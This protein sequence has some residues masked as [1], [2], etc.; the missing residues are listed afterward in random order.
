MN[1]AMVL[2][3]ITNEIQF[4]ISDK[5]NPVAFFAVAVDRN[6][7]EVDYFNVVCFGK[8][9]ENVSK[10]CVRGQE[11]LVSGSFQLT[12]KKDQ[13]TRITQK[14]YTLV[15]NYIKFLRKPANSQV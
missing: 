1:N 14:Y 7:D 9:A 8:V 11:I 2:G 15:A 6:A 4:K 13:E 12:Q 10:H 3:K 5:G